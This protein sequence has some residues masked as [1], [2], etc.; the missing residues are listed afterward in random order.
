MKKPSNSIIKSVYFFAPLLFLL[1][2]AVF[3]SNTKVLADKLDDGEWTQDGS[4]GATTITF[5]NEGALFSGNDIVI[6][7]PSTSD[8]NDIGTDISCTNQGTPVRTNNDTDNS[9]TI[10]LDNTIDA[11]TE[12]TI[13]M[14]DGLDSY[15]PSTFGQHSVAINTQDDDDVLI[16]FGVAIITDDNTTDITASVPLFVNMAI[17]TTTIEL[18]T[19]STAS[20]KED[21]QTYTFN[22]NNDGGITVE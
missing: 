20:V 14:D 19:L 16:D 5:T 17:D 10:T 22:S 15:V 12:I 11:S 8:I 6:T 13:V 9:I 1:V 7:F 4:P 21:D 3:F 2:G 18:G